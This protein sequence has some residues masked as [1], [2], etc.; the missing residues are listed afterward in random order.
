MKKIVFIICALFYMTGCITQTLWEEAPRGEHKVL[1]KDELSPEA[2]A[3]LVKRAEDKNLNDV[4]L[5]S[6]GNISVKKSAWTRWGNYALV[7]LATPVTVAADT[8]IIGGVIV[9]HIIANSGYGNPNGSRRDDREAPI[10]DN[11][12]QRSK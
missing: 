7:G 5:M 9:V 3:E 1:K 8:V 4:Y 2:Y 11:L 12:F 10:F 6:T